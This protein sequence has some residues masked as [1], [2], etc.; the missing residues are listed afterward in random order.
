[1]CQHHATGPI[2]TIVRK[3]FI[4]IG[5]A[6]SNETVNNPIGKTHK[7]ILKLE[8]YT[9]EEIILAVPLL[10]VNDR[11][12]FRI[13]YFATFLSESVNNM[14]KQKITAGGY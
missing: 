12:A 2:H 5:Y 4:K 8:T 14:I 11:P 13:D 1:M 6:S 10:P 7:M 9:T 3:L